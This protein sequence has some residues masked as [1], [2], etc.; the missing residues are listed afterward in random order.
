MSSAA[1]TI[2][3]RRLFVLQLYKDTPRRSIT[4][5]NWDASVHPLICP[6]RTTW[7]QSSS[8]TCYR[9][10]IS[11][12][13]V[14]C[15]S[16]NFLPSYIEWPQPA[17]ARIQSVTSFLTLWLSATKFGLA[18]ANMP[19]PLRIRL[20]ITLIRLEKQLSKL[21]LPTTSSSMMRVIIKELNKDS[22]Q[23]ARF[24]KITLRIQKNSRT[25]N[26]LPLWQRVI[27]P[28]Y[29]P[30]AAQWDW[31]YRP[32]GSVSQMTCP[33]RYTRQKRQGN[34][35]HW[36]QNCRA[37]PENRQK[38]TPRYNSGQTQA[39]LCSFFAGLVLCTTWRGRKVA[40]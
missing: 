39:V 5:S 9:N 12:G 10:R 19:R 8:T 15:L 13:N 3:T 33:L 29:T 24:V 37:L 30:C 2:T 16:M 26:T 35:L 6:T 22:L 27:N 32:G 11:Q 7:W 14:L 36:Q 21:S 1:S 17:N 40:R 31:Y 34:L 20:I 23:Q 25:A 18:W 4:S 28:K 38:G